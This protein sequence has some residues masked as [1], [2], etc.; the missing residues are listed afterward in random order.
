M[1]CAADLCEGLFQ[2]GGHLYVCGDG[3]AMAKDV[4]EALVTSVQAT[5]NCSGAEAEAKL[6]DL[7]KSGRYCREI[8][9]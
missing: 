1:Q 8:W 7:Q 9:N 4:H 3:Q 6:M 2:R 5:M